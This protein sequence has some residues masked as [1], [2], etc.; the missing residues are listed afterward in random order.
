[1]AKDKKNNLPQPHDATF[2]K[3]FSKKY[4]A[5][6]ILEKKSTRRNIKREKLTSILEILLIYYSSA[7]KDFTEE[8]L[9]KRIRALD[10]KGEKFMTILQER[11]QIG[12]EQGLEQGLELGKQAGLKEGKAEMVKNLIRQGVDI[13]IILNA[14]GLNRKEIEDIK[15][16][17]NN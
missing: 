3:L 2:K 4:I 14:S 7:N 5:K 1:M 11:E 15:N 9:T 10:G 6:D 13:E 17:M 16:Q 8:E 12:L